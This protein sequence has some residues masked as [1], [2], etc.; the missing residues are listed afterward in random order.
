MPLG[1][2]FVPAVLRISMKATATVYRMVAPKHLCPWGVKAMDL[3][4]RGGY[5]IEDHRLTSEEENESYKKGHGYSETPQIFIKGKHIGGYDALREF[6]GKGPDPKQGDTYQPVVAVFS[7]A[8]LMAMSTCWAL[9][10]TIRPVR[11]CELFVAFSMCLLGTLKLRDLL[12]F[13][14]GFVQYDL[15][16]RRYVP[17]SYV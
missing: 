9:H 11:V 2:N 13:A 4:K 15:L 6:L 5:E 16:A 8:F 12:S 14:T 3:L 10:T 1:W 17:Y 7:V